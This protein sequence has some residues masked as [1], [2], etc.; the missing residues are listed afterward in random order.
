MFYADVLLTIL[1]AC[2][3]TGPAGYG[4]K[5]FLDA[6]KTLGCRFDIVKGIDQ[7]GPGNRIC[8]GLADEPS[9][10]GNTS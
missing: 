6:L 7:A 3:D 9:D 5:R 8:I 2:P 10:P 1:D 4:R